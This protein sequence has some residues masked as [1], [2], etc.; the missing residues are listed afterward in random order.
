MASG[1]LLRA[2]IN[3]TVDE[4]WS[5]ALPSSGSAVRTP[6]NG[7]L[8]TRLQGLLDGILRGDKVA[9]QELVNRSYER[10]PRLAQAILHQD[11]PRLEKP[12]QAGDLLHEAPLRLL[13]RQ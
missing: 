7:D 13:S 2:Q 12:H 9:R 4:T 8:R 6:M 1:D 5:D 10:L 11:F 3:W